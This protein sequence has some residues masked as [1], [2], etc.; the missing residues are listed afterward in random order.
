MPGRAAPICDEVMGE[1][2]VCRGASEI[3]AHEKRGER[4][5]RLDVSGTTACFDLMVRAKA[6]CPNAADVT[7]ASPPA[8]PILRVAL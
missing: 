4:T 6:T 3:E 7:Q 5:E 1:K 2:V 8:A